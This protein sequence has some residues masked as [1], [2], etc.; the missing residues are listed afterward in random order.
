MPLQFSTISA[1]QLARGDVVLQEGQLWQC[2]LKHSS[3]FINLDSREQA[4]LPLDSYTRVNKL[5]LIPHEWKVEDGR[6]VLKGRE[7]GLGPQHEIEVEGMREFQEME[8]I[9]ES[10]SKGI[11]MEYKVVCLEKTEPKKYLLV[12]IEFL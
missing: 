3:L 6:V 7:L 9:K 2:A 1:D 10:A 11:K 8:T 5:E 4:P 12:A